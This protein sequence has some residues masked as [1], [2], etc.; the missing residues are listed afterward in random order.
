MND[1][2]ST[3]L[4]KV[5][6]KDKQKYPAVQQIISNRSVPRLFYRRAGQLFKAMI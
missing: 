1:L 6:R 4:E 5:I 3:T 2:E